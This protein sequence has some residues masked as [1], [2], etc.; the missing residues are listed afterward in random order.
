MKPLAHNKGLHYFTGSSVG[1]TGDAANAF[2]FN[3]LAD[4]AINFVKTGNH[5]TL[6]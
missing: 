3:A 4:F 1:L 5:L 6:L 2:K